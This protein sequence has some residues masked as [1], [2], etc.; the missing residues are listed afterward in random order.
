MDENEVTE[1]EKLI[2]SQSNMEEEC[3]RKID[4]GA[5]PG[6]SSNHHWGA[7]RS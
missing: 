1:I 3:W 4:R 6:S 5:F 7:L 2:S